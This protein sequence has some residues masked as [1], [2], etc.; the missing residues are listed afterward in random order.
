MK[1][2]GALF[3]IVISIL[4]S[5]QGLAH[6]AFTAFDRNQVIDLE[7]EVVGQSPRS[8]AV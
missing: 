3:A 2:A 6:H 4:M 8:I 7:G 5:S 1:T